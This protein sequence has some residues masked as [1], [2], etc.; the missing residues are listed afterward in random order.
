MREDEI[1]AALL[2]EAE[3]ATPA[4]LD[5]RT[6]GGDQDVSI[7]EIILRWNADRLVNENGHNSVGGYVRDNEG[8]IVG[9]EHHVYYRMDAEFILRFYDEIERD[10]AADNL[11][12]GFLPYEK[13]PE[14]FDSDT[15]EWEVGTISPQNN[16]VMEPDWYE[17]SV[18]LSFRYVKRVEDTDYDAIEDVSTGE[19]R[20]E[21]LDTTISETY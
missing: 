15:T 12:M 9:I 14:D 7:P 17:S 16:A 8:D 3:A 13:D 1:V 11:V 6:D 19:H 18:N 10:Q 2:D 20:D 5:V 21:T 4:S